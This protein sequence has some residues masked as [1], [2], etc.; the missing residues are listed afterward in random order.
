MLVL[1]FLVV[2][3]SK[4]ASFLSND[5][6]INSAIHPHDFYASNA[7][8][9]YG[10]KFRV[11]LMMDA[12]LKTR[13][14]RFMSGDHRIDDLDRLFLGQ[15]DHSWSQ[16]AFRE[17]GD[18]V[19]HRNSRKQ[20]FVTEIARDIYTS[21]DI[22][23][24]GLRGKT[25]T[26]DDARLAA[27]SNLRIATDSQLKI[28]TGLNRQQAQSKLSSAN[29]KIDC[30]RLINQSEQKVLQYLGNTFIW[31]P[32]FSSDQLWQEFQFVLGK[33]NLINCDVNLPHENSKLYLAQYVL[34]LLH[35]SN[36]DL[37]NGNSA[38]LYAGF[39]NKDKLLEVKIEFVFNDF[40]KPI[41]LPVCLFL[42]NYLPVNLCDKS[43]L[44]SDD[45]L[46]YNGWR[47][48]IEIKSNGMLAM[49]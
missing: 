26:L 10:F 47:W 28:G 6:N 4:L 19:A 25:V 35:L 17:I 33:N 48:P 7:T 40:A 49:L 13:A 38:K 27:Q 20:G 36:I 34:A 30:G 8:G 45:E 5:L 11:S 24:R 42:T 18:F 2:V 32:A 21:A 41:L 12:E 3:L 1:G 15:R 39:H 22:W 43:I 46:F 16:A 9:L 31:R 37:A 14:N 44:M 23:S 29:R